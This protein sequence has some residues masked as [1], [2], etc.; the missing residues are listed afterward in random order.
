[1]IIGRYAANHEYDFAIT[2][3]VWIICSFVEGWSTHTLY[4]NPEIFRL[5][6]E[7]I[8]LMVDNM[9]LMDMIKEEREKNGSEA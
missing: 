9:K 2:F 3:A 4:T 5:K 8:E 1:M 6:K 7:N